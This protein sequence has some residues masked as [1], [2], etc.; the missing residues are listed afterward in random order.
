MPSACLQVSGGP[1][2]GA[3]QRPCGMANPPSHNC[4]WLG[5]TLRC[6]LLASGGHEAFH[7][8]CPDD[9]AVWATCWGDIV[10]GMTGAVYRPHAVARLL[11]DEGQ[12]TVT[13]CQCSGRCQCVRRAPKFEWMQ[14]SE[15][16]ECWKHMVPKLVRA[17]VRSLSDCLSHE[18]WWQR[19]PV[20]D[21]KVHQ[22]GGELGMPAQVLHVTNQG[23]SVRVRM[24]EGMRGRSLGRPSNAPPC[25]C[26]GDL[27]EAIVL[28][29]LVFNKWA[30]LH[31]HNQQLHSLTVDH[32]FVDING[33]H[34]SLRAMV[35]HVGPTR[36]Q[37]H[38]I[39]HILGRDVWWLCD[40]ASVS[41]GRPPATSRKVTFLLYE[42]TPTEMVGLSQGG[43]Q[44][45][46]GVRDGPPQSVA[47]TV[48]R[49]AR[50]MPS[51]TPL[52]AMAL[53]TG[54]PESTNHIGDA[55][56][57]PSQFATPTVNRHAP[58]VP[59][60]TQLPAMALPTGDPGYATHVG[61]VQ[62]TPEFIEAV[63]KLVQKQRVRV[64][65]H[66]Q[67]R[68]QAHQAHL[69]A[70]HEKE[71]DERHA[72]QG[73]S[74]RSVSESIEQD[75]ARSAALAATG[76]NAFSV[77]MGAAPRQQTA[78]PKTLQAFVDEHWQ[79][80]FTVQ[81]GVMC[82]CCSWAAET[83][84]RGVKRPPKAAAALVNGTYG[85]GMRMMIATPKGWRKDV[86]EGH[87]G[88]SRGTTSSRKKIDNP[89]HHHLAAEESFRVHCAERFRALCPSASAC[90]VNVAERSTVFIRGEGMDLGVPM[91]D[92]AVA[93]LS[94]LVEVYIGLRMCTSIRAIS[95]RIRLP[96]NRAIMPLG[97]G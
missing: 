84:C 48:D 44:S 1:Q 11:A 82:I 42:R 50:S 57:S 93:I 29:L 74:H 61:Y 7:D 67:V 8:E 66:L 21:V 17:G 64:K 28:S 47:T 39:A 3:R 56:P 65:Q 68:V 95:E 33:Y 73:M 62:P 59:S 79:L 27:Q 96:P 16:A 70:R 12:P 91:S 69:R 77:M 19:C 49:H 46:R 76:S 88:V 80:Q 97:D 6:L 75:R 18:Q 25:G 83:D 41:R 52:R 22:A 92:A 51:I 45:I 86:L 78:G 53:A 14:Q 4:C 24:R 37:G 30:P 38:F 90:A 26:V 23:Q 63:A 32:E 94:R 5:T 40:D 89:G 35:L 20:C 87:L 15:M 60:N 31:V 36:E 55:Q 54:D 13:V 2:G 43:L 34:W 9:V 58:S 81:G 10:A 85:M 71:W 72:G